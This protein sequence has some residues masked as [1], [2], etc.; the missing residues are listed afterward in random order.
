[1]VHSILQFAH[2]RVYLS[3]RVMYETLQRVAAAASADSTMP[4]LIEL[5]FVGIGLHFDKGPL[6]R[7]YLQR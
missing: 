2:H 5:H 1:M 6:S 3:S 4:R 7:Y